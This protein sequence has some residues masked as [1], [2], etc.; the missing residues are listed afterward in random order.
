MNTTNV[1][2]IAVWFDTKDIKDIVLPVKAEVHLN[3]WQLKK[4]KTNKIKQFLDIGLM[5]EVPNNSP[6]LHIFLP[7]AIQYSIEDLGKTLKNTDT[8]RAVF[9]EPWRPL[10]DPDPQVDTFNVVDFET[11]ILFQIFPVPKANYKVNPVQDGSTIDISLPKTE[12]HKKY[13]R[14]RVFS[15]DFSPIISEYKPKNAWLESAFTVTEIFDIH[16]NEKRNLSDDL[17]KI[18]H[19]QGYV[20]LTK[21]HVFIMRSDK[22]DQISSFPV[23]IDSRTL[24]ANIWN[25]YIGPEYLREKITAYH[26]KQKVDD[27]VPLFSYPDKFKSYNVYSKFRFQKANWITI[28]VFILL[29]SVISFVSSLLVALIQHYTCL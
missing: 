21:T 1:D 27:S 3:F 28:L 12:Q 9:N 7:F 17:L 4:D 16:V 24:E 15:N 19:S 26:W 10:D 13:I 11:N 5:I 6:S 14:F 22:Y 20:V 8:L 18:L 25:E 2:G 23:S 29:L